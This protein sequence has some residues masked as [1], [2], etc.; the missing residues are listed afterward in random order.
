MCNTKIHSNFVCVYPYLKK[1]VPL[2]EGELAF[3]YQ[4]CIKKYIYLKK[5]IFIGFNKLNNNI[6][7]M[8]N[9]LK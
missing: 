2:R 5:Y 3:F 9:K 1:R 6:V 7:I 8:N 4:K